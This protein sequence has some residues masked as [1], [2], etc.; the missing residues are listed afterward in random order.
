MTRRME[1]EPIVQIKPFSGAKRKV[2]GGH[3]RQTDKALI[4]SVG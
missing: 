3:S 4:L 1:M 2:S